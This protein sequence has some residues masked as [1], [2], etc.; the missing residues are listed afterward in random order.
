M[1]N[2]MTHAERWNTGIAGPALAETPLAVPERPPVALQPMLSFVVPAHNEERLLRGTLEAIHQAASATGQ[3]Y[4][5]I[6]V[7]DASTDHT[8]AIARDCQARVVSV[9]HRHIAASRNAGASAAG[10]ELLVFVDADT[11]VNPGVVGDA[12]AA[13]RDGA[14]GGGAAIRFDEP[15][16]FYARV[17]L[18]IVVLSFR[19]NRLAAG[20]FV[21]CT[22]G[23]FAAVGGFDETYFGAEEIIISRALRR[24]GRFVVLRSAVLTSGRKLRTYTARELLRAMFSLVR[25]GPRAVQRREGLEIWYGARRE[26]PRQ[27]R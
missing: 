1:V 20:C 4:E 27:D 15:I 2:T 9:T 17:L 14:I 7:D 11:R 12:V 19:I 26:D 22:R 3:P 16:P 6:V 10:G 5:V 13:V 23:A 8:A 18:P 24:Q 21:F 25:R